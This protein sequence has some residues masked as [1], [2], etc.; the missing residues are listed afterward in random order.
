VTGLA[1]GV[2]ALATRR[3]E[4]RVKR[5]QRASARFASNRRHTIGAFRMGAD[6]ALSAVGEVGTLPA[7]DVG[8]VSM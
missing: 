1:I 5:Q 6:G 2:L 3:R 7:G 8:L 4:D